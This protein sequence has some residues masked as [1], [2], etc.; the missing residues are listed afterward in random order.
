MRGDNHRVADPVDAVDHHRRQLR[1]QNP[2]TILRSHRPRAPRT[3]ASGQPGPASRNVCQNQIIRP[4]TGLR[5]ALVA[6]PN[7]LRNANPA[8]GV[9]D[10][11]RDELA[12]LGV[13]AVALVNDVASSG[14]AP[15]RPAS[16]DLDISR[17]AF[18]PVPVLLEV[19]VSS[20]RTIAAATPTNPPEFS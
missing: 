17:P 6:V 14:L 7:V 8:T 2:A 16:P 18:K 1:K 5:V 4:F 9:L 13:T 3:R 11:D 15:L 10:L 19:L 12:R 20:P